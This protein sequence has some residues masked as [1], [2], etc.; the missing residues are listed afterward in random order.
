MQPNVVLLAGGCGTRLWP[1][2]TPKRPKQFMTLPRVNISSFQLSL[3]RS[4]SITS[5]Q[6]IT[7]ITNAEY[8]DL[9]CQQ[10]CDLDLDHNNFNIILERRSNNTGIA[11]YCACIFLLKK[12]LYGLTYFFP[13]D[14]FICEEPYFFKEVLSNVDEE[15]IN[16]FGQR[17]SKPCSNFGYIIEGENISN[18]YYKVKNF[19]EKPGY[20]E[21]E[22]LKQNNQKFYRNLGIYLATAPVL[23]SEFQKFHKDLPSVVFDFSN[24]K[25]DIQVVYN[26]LPIDKMI[27]EFSQLLNLVEIEFEWSDIGSIESLYQYCSG[28]GL[29]CRTDP[30]YIEEFNNLNKKFK[31][32]H[33][34]D[35]LH[36]I[37]K[38]LYSML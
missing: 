15:R 7:I 20:K 30:I 5:P 1:L 27:S 33:S 16:L 4:L 25:Y 10:I 37:K 14:H 22:I 19:I 11:I 17:A 12:E 28:H 36:I 29:D 9:L 8:Q 32:N 38:D 31:L 24:N 3:K 23:Y 35:G 2:S 21:V 18:Y 13:T 34:N 6:K 26:N